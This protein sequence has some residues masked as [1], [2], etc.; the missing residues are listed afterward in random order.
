MELFDQ[1]IEDYLQTLVN[2]GDFGI[3]LYSDKQLVVT[4]IHVHFLLK[5]TTEKI[6]VPNAYLCT[7][8]PDNDYWADLLVFEDAVVERRIGKKDVYMTYEAHSHDF[9]AFLFSLS[10]LCLDATHTNSYGVKTVL[11]TAIFQ[12]TDRNCLTMCYGTAPNETTATWSFFML[13]LGQVITKVLRCYGLEEN[14]RIVEGNEEVIQ[15]KPSSIFCS[16]APSELVHQE[17]KNQRIL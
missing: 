3:I 1:Q 5:P 12:T 4:D 13:N 9:V 14:K 11:F 16:S 2:N 10:M 7:Q 6:P 15:R 17:N 8:F